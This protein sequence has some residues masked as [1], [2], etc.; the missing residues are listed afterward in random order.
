MIVQDSCC[1]LV[2]NVDVV[3]FYPK[4]LKMIG[5]WPSNFFLLFIPILLCMRHPTPHAQILLQL[6]KII[7]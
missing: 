7:K 5:L 6:E 2:I 3:S 4:K 1:K